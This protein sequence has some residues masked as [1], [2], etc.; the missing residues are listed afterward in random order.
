MPYTTTKPTIV[1]LSDDTA[2][3]FD[4]LSDGWNTIKN[5]HT[6]PAQELYARATAIISTGKDVPDT[7]K[8]LEDAG[9]NIV[10][11]AI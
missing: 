8:R 9:F 5:R 4:W 1:V 6:L 3:T 11:G 2:E 10:R 7:I